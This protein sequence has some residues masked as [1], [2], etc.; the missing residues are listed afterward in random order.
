LTTSSA[1]ERRP[2][3]GRAA[4]RQPLPERV[5]ATERKETMTHKIYVRDDET[6]KT[7][8]VGER[9]SRRD[10]EQSAAIYNRDPIQKGFVYVVSAA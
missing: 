7:Y 5:N 6:G 9:G 3:A 8:Y 10:A 1:T 4:N 2:V